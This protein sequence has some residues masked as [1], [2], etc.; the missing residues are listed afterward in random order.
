MATEGTTQYLRRHGFR[1]D[2]VSKVFRENRNILEYIKERKVGMI[3]NTPSGTYEWKDAR[4][5]RT[6]AFS[7]RVPCFTTIPSAS[8]AVKAIEVRKKSSPSLLWLQDIRSSYL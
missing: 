7:Y 5:I 4:K 3:F 8:A 2:T 6:V 1:V